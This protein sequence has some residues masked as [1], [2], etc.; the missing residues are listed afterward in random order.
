MLFDSFIVSR[1]SLLRGEI[2]PIFAYFLL[3]SAFLPF[4]LCFLNSFSLFLQ[5]SVFFFFTANLTN[6]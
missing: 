1:T 4:F 3:I 5:G 2:V 6:R